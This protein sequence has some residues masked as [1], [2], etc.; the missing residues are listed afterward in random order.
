MANVLCLG[1]FIRL[2]RADAE[3]VLALDAYLKEHLDQSLD[4]RLEHMHPSGALLW[5]I[6]KG[7]IG[8]GATLRELANVTAAGCA[9]RGGDRN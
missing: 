8:D 6:H 7:S 9:F 3:S 4:H 2:P 5:E 1:N